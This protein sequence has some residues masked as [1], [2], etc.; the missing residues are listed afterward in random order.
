MKCFSN[1][2][3][4]LVIFAN[5]TAPPENISINKRILGNTSSVGKW[6]LKLKKVRQSFILIDGIIKALFMFEFQL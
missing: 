6:Y 2:L 5:N 4:Q 1:V 3:L